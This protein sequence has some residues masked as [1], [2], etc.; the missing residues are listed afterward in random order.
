MAF[1]LRMYYAHFLFPHINMQ[2]SFFRRSNGLTQY[3][4]RAQVSG[5]I[6]NL[7]N[8]YLRI[9]ESG[10]DVFLHDSTFLHEWR[11]F[12]HKNYYF[13]FGEMTR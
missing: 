4:D 9:V 10:E 12:V 11:Y 2:I 6:E 8:I 3:T 1:M 13:V 5:N 7:I